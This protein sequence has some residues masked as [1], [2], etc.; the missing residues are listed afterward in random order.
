MF[1]K[2]ASQFLLN[3]FNRS[4][5]ISRNFFVTP[6]NVSKIQKFPNSILPD[7]IKKKPTKL[8]NTIQFFYVF[9]F[10]AWI[11]LM[12]S[13][14]RNEFRTAVT[15]F[16]QL[17]EEKRIPNVVEN[18][19]KSGVSEPKSILQQNELVTVTNNSFVGSEPPKFLV[20]H[21]MLFYE[22]S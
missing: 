14:E 17:D 18:F 3:Q 16:Y 4:T 21:G 8:E 22:M 13:E 10:G 7:V 1:A 11:G 6:T 20:F 5:P 2:R 9:V 19:T 15:S 12:D